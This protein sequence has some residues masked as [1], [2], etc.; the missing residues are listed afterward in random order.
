MSRYIG[1]RHRVKK[2]ADGEARPTQIAI[3]NETGSVTSYDLETETNELDFLLN[4]FVTKTR[5]AEPDEDLTKFLAHH[6]IWRE[7]EKDDKFTQPENL[8]RTE[9]KTRF[10]I[11]SVPAAYDGFK[12]DDIIG[13]VLG[14]SGDRFNFALSRR[15]EEINA[16]V[17]R[18]PGYI[19]KGERGT[20]DKDNDP[21][22]L[23]TMVRDKRHL[24][25]QVTRRDRDMIK[26]RENL[27]DRVKAMK[28]RIGAEQRLLQRQIGAIFCSTEGKY[29]EGN[30]EAIFQAARAN[31]VIVNALVDEE[32]ACIKKLT[33]AVQASTYW[34]EILASV[35]GMGPLIAAP[36][37][38]ATVDIRRFQT[39]PRFKAFCG[40]HVGLDGN[41]IRAQRE[42]RPIRA[43]TAPT[44][45]AT[46]VQLAE[47]AAED[48]DEAEAAQTEPKWNRV[49]R[50]A[51]HLFVS[52][53]CNRRPDSVWGVKLRE[54][55]VTLR[56]KHP[57][58]VLNEKGK[59]RYTKGHI[60][61]MAVWRTAT[62][63]CEW[64][65]KAA[66]EVEKKLA[67]GKQPVA[68]APSAPVTAEPSPEPPPLSMETAALE[69]AQPV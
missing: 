53:Q 45:A 24:F 30:L 56:A 46:E 41:F 43:E 62:K 21:L 7:L 47:T 6:I 55:K 9:G 58:I 3:I 44:E 26:V 17:Y 27:F 12:P 11:K 10:E 42:E 51:F 61:R 1:I 63:F 4:R 22:L 36:I 25:Y 16:T 33:K 13:S 28:A 65:F 8:R 64:F 54:Y 59:K 2:T 69:S 35:E 5:E 32:Q 66:W 31:N 29:P 40:L 50:Q 67:Q 60:H 18:V 38:A 68:P 23:A 15:G 52:D 39:K 34:T 19:L 49:A 48:A 20:A 14:G 37:L 57:E